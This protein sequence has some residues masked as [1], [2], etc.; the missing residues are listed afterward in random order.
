MI[1]LW[2]QPAEIVRKPRRARPF[3]LRTR[4]AQL[5]SSNSDLDSVKSV[6]SKHDIGSSSSSHRKHEFAGKTLCAIMNFGV[7]RLLP[8][9]SSRGSELAVYGLTLRSSRGRPVLK[10]S[11]QIF[12]RVF[13]PYPSGCCS[14]PTQKRDKIL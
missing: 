7:R 4:R 6:S 14:P 5:E 1:K 9:A 8:A 10:T 3:D 13:K 12:R 11:A 2:R